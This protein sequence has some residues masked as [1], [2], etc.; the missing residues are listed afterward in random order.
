MSGRNNKPQT[1]LQKQSHH[2]SL[3]LP[4]PPKSLA[5]SPNK[6]E[7]N[8]LWIYYSKCYEYYVRKG[9]MGMARNIRF[10]QAE[11]LEKEGSLKGAISSYFDVFSTD[12][13]GYSNLAELQIPEIKPQPIVAPAVVN[14]IRICKSKLKWSD[15]VLR[16]FL[17]EEHYEPSE[18]PRTRYNFKKRVDMLIDYI[19]DADKAAEKYHI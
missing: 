17:S 16:D 8:D 11:I 1:T 6:R 12:L 15:K 4:D 10:S 3:S 19:Y 14:R 13:W 9:E 2:S 5:I 7:N 18:L